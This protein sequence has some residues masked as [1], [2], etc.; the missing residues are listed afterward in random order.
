MLDQISI[1]LCSVLIS[2]ISVIPC[3][4]KFSLFCHILKSSVKYGCFQNKS[5]GLSAD[6]HKAVNVTQVCRL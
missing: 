4:A 2:I 3:V 5:F 6:T 1:T